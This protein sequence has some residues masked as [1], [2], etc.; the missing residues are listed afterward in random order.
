MIAP[1]PRA[2]R[3]PPTEAVSDAS[4]I[5]G[6]VTSL[7]LAEAA[8]H[9]GRSKSALLR[10]IKAGR[11]SATRD[12][13]TGAWLIEPAELHRLYP[14]AVSGAAN[15]EP[16]TTRDAR[17]PPELR[18]RLADALDQISDLRRQRD[19]ADDERRAVQARLDA[20]LV[21]QRPARRAWWRW[22]R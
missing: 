18:P 11:L 4:R 20:L 14:E 19:R 16:P 3:A 17:K 1:F 9:A 7:T 21:D 10:S 12:A 2:R 13:L 8:R 15:G 5:G 6:D 22:R